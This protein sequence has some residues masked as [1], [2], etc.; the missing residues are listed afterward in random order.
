VVLNL[1]ISLGNLLT[2][3]SFIAGG[4][5][6]VTTMRGAVDMMALRLSTV[7]VEVKKLAEVLI[8]LGKYEERFLRVERDITDLRHGVGFIVSPPKRPG[9]PLERT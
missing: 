4:F 8:T 6:F 9:G 3:G 2:I 1:D 5:W 7:E